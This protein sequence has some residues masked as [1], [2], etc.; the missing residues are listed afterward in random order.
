MN[1]RAAGATRAL[2]MGGVW[3]GLP[4]SNRLETGLAIHPQA[5]ARGLGGRLCHDVGLYAVR[6]HSATSRVARSMASGWS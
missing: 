6:N 1:V 3:C 5:G 2:G 4:A